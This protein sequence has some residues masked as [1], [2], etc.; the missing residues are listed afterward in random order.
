[1]EGY[2]FIVRVRDEEATLEA[3]LRSLFGIL[4]SYEIL[5]FLNN[6]SDNSKA[7]AKSLAAIN[8]HI[9]IFEYNYVLARPGFETY[10]TDDSSNHSLINY[11]NWSVKKAAYKWRVKWDAD[12]I[13]TPQLLDFMNTFDL[14]SNGS[15]RLG[16]KNLDGSVEMNDYISSCLCCYKKDTFWEMPGYYRNYVPHILNNIFITHVSSKNHTKKYWYDAPWFETVRTAEAFE[17][18]AN[19]QKLIQKY[20]KER[21]GFV[22][23]ENMAEAIE[24]TLRFISQE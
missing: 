18:N 2:S 9:K 12:F 5:V 22:R 19:Y 20:G 7:I 6:I 14:K 17:A 23:S 1:M 16:A 3:S 11:Y 24:F 15:L 8:P 10:V 4:V 13:M 21:R